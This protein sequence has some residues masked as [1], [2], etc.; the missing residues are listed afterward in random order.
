MVKVACIKGDVLNEADVKFVG[1]G[2]A[3]YATVPA[4][5]GQ[6]NSIV[7]A[8]RDAAGNTSYVTKEYWIDFTTE[9][10]E[11]TQSFAYNAAGCCT[12]LNGISLKWDERYRLTAAVRDS[13]FNIQYSYDVLGRR[14][15]RSFVDA[16]SP[17]QDQHRALCL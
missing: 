1:S 7:A 4:L 8:I 14:V 16:T 15:S 10:T 9:S 2:N 13:L 11:E 17:S 3:F 12:N 6:T 5:A